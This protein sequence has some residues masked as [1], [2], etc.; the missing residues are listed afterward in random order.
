MVSLAGLPSG[1]ADWLSSEYVRSKVQPSSNTAK[2]IKIILLF[3]AHF[4]SCRH[5]R[6]PIWRAGYYSCRPKHSKTGPFE[7]WM[8]LSGF[9]MFFDKMVAICLNF[10]WLLT[11]QIFK[12]YDRW[13]DAES[14]NIWPVM[15]IYRHFWSVIKLKAGQR[16]I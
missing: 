3:W 13:C 2:K 9:Q 1:E 6:R 16:S 8:L 11:C 12:W 10:K 14:P 7:I 5:L 4:E 15:N